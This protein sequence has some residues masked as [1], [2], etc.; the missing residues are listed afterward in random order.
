MV[1]SARDNV[2]ELITQSLCE[3]WRNLQL[4]VLHDTYQVH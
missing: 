4:G 3:H 1:Q 2:V